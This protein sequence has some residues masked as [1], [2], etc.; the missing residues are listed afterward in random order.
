MYKQML[1]LDLCYTASVCPK[2]Y[3]ENL[4]RQQ[5]QIDLNDVPDLLFMHSTI[6]GFS[7]SYPSLLMSF[8]VNC[9]VLDRIGAQEELDSCSTHRPHI[10]N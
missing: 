3:I 10:L 4:S 2:V 6:G 9:T 5:K 1:R 8:Y 7:G